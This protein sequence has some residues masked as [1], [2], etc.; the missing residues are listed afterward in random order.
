M[1]LQQRAS[2]GRSSLKA[3]GL[4]EIV[5]NQDTICLQYSLRS[6]NSQNHQNSQGLICLYVLHCT[7]TANKS[8][9][10]S[11]TQSDG[12]YHSARKTTHALYSYPDM[13]QLIIIQICQPLTLFPSSTAGTGEPSG[14]KHL[15]SRSFFQILTA[16]NVELRVTSNTMNAPAASLQYTR[17]M[18]PNRS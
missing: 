11:V 16:S 9:L 17:V 6:P 13:V 15:L 5:S 14:P 4:K 1:K 7:S 2:D 18:L 10:G 12:R 3:H 8:H